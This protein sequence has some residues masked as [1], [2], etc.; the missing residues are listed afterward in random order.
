MEALDIFIP[1][2]KP[3]VAQKLLFDSQDK[4]E[5][6]TLLIIRLFKIIFTQTKGALTLNECLENTFIL[7]KYYEKFIHENDLPASKFYFFV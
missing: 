3:D 2:S 5:T 1:E 4:N 7:R 6:L